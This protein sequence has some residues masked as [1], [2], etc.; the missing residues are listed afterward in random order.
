MNES[1]FRREAI[2]AVR[3]SDLNHGKPIASYPPIGK[4]MVIGC[5][6]FVVCFGSLMTIVDFSRTENVTG[7]LN[8][9]QAESKI[10]ANQTGV[11][12]KVY[13]GDGDFVEAGEKLFEVNIDKSTGQSQTLN[14]NIKEYLDAEISALLK[15]Q[16]IVTYEAQLSL[17]E[18]EYKRKINEQTFDKSL[19]KKQLIAEQKKRAQSSYERTQKAFDAKLVGAEQLLKAKNALDNVSLQLIDINSLISDTRLDVDKINIDNK[20]I[21][22][23]LEKELH[24]IDQNLMQLRRQ[25]ALSAADTTLHVKASTAGVVNSLLIKEGQ[26][27]RANDFMAAITPSNSQIVAELFLPSKAI[28]FVEEEQEVNFKFEAFPYQKYGIVSGTLTSIAK[29][30]VL[31]SDL[32][33][34]KDKPTILYKAKARL[35][36]QA[37]PERFQD[38]TFQSGMKL[39]AQIILESQTLF[40]WLKMMLFS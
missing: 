4:W 22:A 36:E 2:E 24:Q 40:S 8:F 38:I 37:M 27:V 29:T 21:N 26:I 9:T 20:R 31:S 11:V 7:Q 13:V 25:I 17:E 12:D 16:K 5:F 34:L 30:G 15:T 6:F 14:R 35:D 18:L 10:Y 1:I 3:S 32:G 19:H 33:I 39:E 23:E 28:A